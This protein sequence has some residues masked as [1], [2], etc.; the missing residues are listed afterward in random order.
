MWSLSAS[1]DVAGTSYSLFDRETG[2]RTRLSETDLARYRDRFSPRVPIA[3]TARDGLAIHGDLTLPKG[4]RGR[5][6]PLVLDVHGGPWWRWRWGFDHAAPFLANRGYAVLQVNY[7]G[8]TGYG[9]RFMEAGIGE[10]GGRMRTDLLDAVAW[11]VEQ[12]V[13]DPKRVAI[14]GW[15]YGGYAALEALT[16]TPEVFAAGIAA[17][18][19]AD[20]VDALESM[21]PCWQEYAARFHAYLGDPADPEQ[22]AALRALSP[23]HR[24][25]RV[26][27][28]CSWCRATAT[29]AA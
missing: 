3:Y 6:L 27:A 18:A 10:F 22:R 12:G 24:L 14:Y 8:S 4:T 21:P 11:A 7:R 9:R 17:S 26:C 13:A 28:R 16:S 15:D 5:K 2:E 1:S 19:P 29:S 25:D 20:W 23:I